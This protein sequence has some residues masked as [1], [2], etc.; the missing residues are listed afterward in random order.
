MVCVY[1]LFLPS[2]LKAA[3]LLSATFGH[4]KATKSPASRCSETLSMIAVE[5]TAVK[6]REKGCLG[7]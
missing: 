2:L 3:G 5:P 1:P 7:I 6:I 4:L